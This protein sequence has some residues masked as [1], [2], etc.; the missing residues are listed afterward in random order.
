[1]EHGFE[2]DAGRPQEEISSVEPRRTTVL[3]HGCHTADGYDVHSDLSENL[4]VT[5]DE[6]ALLRTFLSAEITAIIHDD[7][8]TG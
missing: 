4:P 5:A 8:E 7:N 1:M 2:Q 6:I 3:S